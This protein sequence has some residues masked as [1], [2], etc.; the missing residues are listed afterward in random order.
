M[1]GQDHY[2]PLRW[3]ATIRQAPSVPDPMLSYQ[4]LYYLRNTVQEIIHWSTTEM[5][6]IGETLFSMVYGSESVIP[7]KI[8]ILSFRT[9]NFDKDN[10]KTKLRLNFDL[11]DE[12]R[13]RAEL[14]LQASDHQRKV[15][16]SMKELN[17][18]KLGPTWESPYKVVMVTRM[19]TYLL[20]D[21]SGKT[22][23]HP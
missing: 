16:L 4:I 10:N 12:K 18:G 1:D 8:G 14:C 22:L 21:L 17:A 6:P 2:I 7:M 19:G 23:T 13:E 3:N 20:K 5:I 11:L 15:T 9:L